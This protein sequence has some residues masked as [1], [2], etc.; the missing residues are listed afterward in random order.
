MTAFGV[1]PL[2]EGDVT[3]AGTRVKQGLPLMFLP[4]VAEM[5]DAFN[6]GGFVSL[7]SF[8]AAA[9]NRGAKQQGTN[10]PL[11][12]DYLTLK[13]AAYVD[14]ANYEPKQVLP[15]FVLA[16]GRE[17]QALSTPK[18]RSALGRWFA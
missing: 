11:T 2:G 8:I 15:A 16:L 12:R 14:K 1:P 13:F 6:D 17:S 10:N 9:N 7:D 3:L 5:A 18:D 4:Q